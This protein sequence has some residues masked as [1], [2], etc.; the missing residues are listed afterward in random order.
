MI[1]S[2]TLIFCVTNAR[3]FPNVCLC[4]YHSILCLCQ[5][6]W[7]LWQGAEGSLFQHQQ[8]DERLGPN[9]LKAELALLLSF[10]PLS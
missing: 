1:Y 10:F 9:S 7:W 2:Q 5:C 3:G 4:L 6:V 8:A